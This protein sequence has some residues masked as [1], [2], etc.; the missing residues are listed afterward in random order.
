MEHGHLLRQ[1]GNS[2][3]DLGVSVVRSSRLARDNDRRVTCYA[4]PAGSLTLRIAVAAAGGRIFI[5]DVCQRLYVVE[6]P[7][8]Q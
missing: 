5:I 6:K 1:V 3:C 7:K 4:K 2:L 8:I